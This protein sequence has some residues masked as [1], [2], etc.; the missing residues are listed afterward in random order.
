MTKL[1]RPQQQATVEGFVFKPAGSDVAQ[2]WQ[3][4]DGEH[5]LIDQVNVRPEPKV[6]K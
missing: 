5:V 2:V 1:N 3:K 4:L 6:T